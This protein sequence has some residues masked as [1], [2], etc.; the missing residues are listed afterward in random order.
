MLTFAYYNSVQST[1]EADLNAIHLFT[2]QNSEDIRVILWVPSVTD[3]MAI[4]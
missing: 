3:P 4:M 2:N 1:A